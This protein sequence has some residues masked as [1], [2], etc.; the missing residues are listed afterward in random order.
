[1]SFAQLAGSDIISARVTLRLAGAWEAEVVV[2]SSD[3]SA[4]QGQ[5]RLEVGADT[6]TGTVTAADADAGNLVQVRL[7]GG[8]GGLGA[9]VAPQGYNNPTRQVVLQDALAVGGEAL[10]ATA[11]QGVL[12][13]QIRSWSRLS[14]T[15]AEAVWTLT[16]HAS[17]TWRVLLDGTVWVGSDTWDEVDASLVTVESEDPANGVVRLALESFAVL[18]G[19]ALDGRHIGQVRYDLDDRALRADVVFGESRGE[20]EEL[21]GAVIREETAH[22]SYLTTIAARAVAQNSDG[23]LEIVPVDS[24]WP[25]L[26][27]VPVRFGAHGVTENRIVPG[28]DVLMIYED[29]DPTRP[30]VLSFSSGQAITLK[31]GA[32]TEVAVEAPLITLGTGARFLAHS[33]EVQ[34]WA[35]SVQAACSVAGIAIPLLPPSVATTAVKGA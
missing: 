21:L 7:V 17:S 22:L 23:T 19:M 28:A 30:T 24:R 14:G 15:V 12:S 33:D 31:V 16:D 26:S 9:T 13:A 2:A 11:D 3:P 35:A 1:M 10:S 27:R 6:L 18:P 4:F 5:V 8:A 25:R 29:G 20:L 34:A 32:L